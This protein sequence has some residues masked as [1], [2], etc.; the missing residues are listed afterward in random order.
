MV[1]NPMATTKKPRECDLYAPIRDY[2]VEN[3]YTV[4]GEVRDCDITATRDDD[5]VIVEMKTGFT[6]DLMLQATQRQ[7]IA[8]SVYVAVPRPK[9]RDLRSKRWSAIRHLLG[10][11]EIGL[12]FVDL[13]RDAPANVEVVLH[14]APAARRRSK[15][16]RAAILTE[17][18]G[19]SG[20]YNH[21]GSNNR[22]IVTAYREQAVRIAACLERFGPLTP[23][24]LRDLGCSA[25][26]QRI[27]HDN[28][29]GWF[30]RQGTGI[31]CLKPEG[32][33]ALATYAE[34]A[35]HFSVQIAV[36]ETSEPY[37]SDG[38]A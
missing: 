38:D 26:A 5:L 15:K 7:K 28:H 27:V 12:I 24:R 31:Y 19:R 25:K 29:Y 17:M 16:A 32:R 22:P 3:G 2:L 36:H 10:R 20:D 21:G 8:D 35:E 14:P 9:A 23:R 11:L 13:D 37:E 30:D 34:L 33:D 1:S 4:R 18:A 6:T